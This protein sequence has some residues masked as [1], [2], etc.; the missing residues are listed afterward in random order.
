MKRYLISSAKE[1]EFK[2]HIE[3]YYLNGYLTSIQT[4]E[5]NLKPVELNWLFKNLPVKED[6]LSAFQQGTG[7]EVLEVQLDASLD[8]F[9]IEYPS[10]RNTHLLPPIWNKLS[11]KNQMIAIKVAKDYR[12]YCIANKDWYNA[13]G[14]AAWLKE[15]HYKNNFRR[16]IN[17]IG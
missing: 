8:D 2:G 3:L 15:G 6:N 13:K 11:I 10:S 7:W 17:K 9:K 1:Q 4:I 14:P 5:T 12:Y 16:T